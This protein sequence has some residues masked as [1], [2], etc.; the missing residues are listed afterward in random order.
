MRHTTPFIVFIAFLIQAVTAQSASADI[1]FDLYN[2]ANG[3]D[4]TQGGN[5]FSASDVNIGTDLDL[6]NDLDAGSGNVGA[7]S[8]NGTSLNRWQIDDTDNDDTLPRYFFDLS[9]EQVSMMNANGFTLTM[10]T[11]NF[12]GG[13]LSLGVNRDFGDTVF[14]YT[15]TEIDGQARFGTSVPF[16]G[17]VTTWSWN[18]GTS[19]YVGPLGQNA[20]SDYAGTDGGG[21]ILFEAVGTTQDSARFNIRRV[22]LTIN[23]VPEPGSVSLLTM[24]FGAFLGF[25]RKRR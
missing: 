22:S 6:D 20:T 19:N 16:P 2:P 21:R 7:V 24:A 14:G 13:F 1:V 8:T 17:E 11:E 25:R 12:T 18:P 9:E 10:E 3:L 5:M 23:S 4:P 15:I